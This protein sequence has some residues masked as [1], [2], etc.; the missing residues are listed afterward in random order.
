MERP[1]F[2]FTSKNPNN[3]RSIITKVSVGRVSEGKEGMFET[4]ALWDTGAESSVITPDVVRAL[5]L[6]PLGRRNNIHAGGISEVNIYAVDILLPN[7]VKINNVLV[8]ECAE[9]YGRFGLI[10]GMDIISMGDFS[11]SGP[12]QART[13]SFSIPSN[14]VVDFVQIFN[15]D[16]R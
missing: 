1:Y 4:T 11:I 2:A 7:K 9:Q 15:N 16:N 10:V 3:C 14:L 6:K 8:S 13:V 12:T 5:D